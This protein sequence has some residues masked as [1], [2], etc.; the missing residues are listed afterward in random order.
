MA[1]FFN[2]QLD[3]I[4]FFY[5]LAFVLLGATCVA[6]GRVGGRIESW[7]VLA[8][9]GFVHGGSEWLDLSALEI[10]DTPEFALAR[11]A[12]MTASFVFL[13]EFARLEAIR[14]GVKLPGRWLYLPLLALVALGAAIDGAT[15]AGIFARYLIGFTGAAGTALVF[16]RFAKGFSGATK[17]LAICAAVGFA[18]YGLA[19]GLIVP[20]SSFW[21][22]SVFNQGAFARVTG[23]PIQLLR[24][25]LAC[26]IAYSIW[27][28]WGQELISEVASARYTRFLHRQFI[29]TIGAMAVI[30]VAGWTLTELLGGMH[31]QTVQRDARG[32]ID[33]LAGRLTGETATVDGM[34]KALAGARRMRAL[35]TGD[36]GSGLG[37]D[38]E[39]AKFVLDLD[40]DA[41]GAQ[42]G[43]ILNTAGA[44]V[45]S[46]VRDDA[47]LSAA[48]DYRA[49]PYF[50]SAMFQSAMAGEAG[51]DFAFEAPSGERAYYASYPIR[52]GGAIVGVAV[53]KRSLVALEAEL[54]QYDR[55]YFLVDPDGVVMLTNRPRLMLQNL[56]P[57]P[58]EKRAA[59][60]RQFGALSD[61][62]MLAQEIVR[63]TW[64]E[65]G[66]ERVY[67]LRRQ[68]DHSG[69]SLVVL[70][71]TREIYASRVL[72]IVITLLVAVMALIY[73]FGR[74]RWV[75][76]SVQMEKRLQLQ[77]LA[78]DL[79]FKATTD[80]LTGIPNRLKFDQA[81]AGEVLRAARYKTLLSLVFYDIDHFKEINDTYG[82]QVGDKVLVQL[83]E[84]VAGGI[85][86]TD[87]LARWGGEEFA[88]MVPGCDGRLALQAAEKLRA[89][90]AQIVFHTVGK[91][92]CSF[93][94]AQYV[95]GDTAAALIARA[96]EALYRAKINGRNRVELADLPRATKPDYMSV[97]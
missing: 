67:A 94:I 24:G 7:P 18:F 46:S 30:L 52:D 10:G 57:L 95:E 42:L 87:M 58:E 39:R 64:T 78:R 28:I 25:V 66:R 38:D 14:L 90:I 73:L 69:W 19:A 33:L 72:G 1:A 97:A 32:D 77:E 35:L 34:V 50:Q 31:R 86:G 96:D 88:I 12:G 47:A 76:D 17:R 83:C 5:G 75:H 22:A 4:L 89:T 65:F 3:F 45:M 6:I 55:A 53:L 20:A 56:W 59:L 81:L 40:V 15:A 85:R 26:G 21:P 16:T 51:H 93:G 43:L 36:H 8:L 29:W 71:P 84:L 80:P 9:F 68:A 82:H 27:A 91:V 60:S 2:T 63:G 41:S 54:Q 79:R 92:T 44:A 13:L 48:T 74:E 11:T 49:A 62:P 61:R 70:T 23:F 37:P